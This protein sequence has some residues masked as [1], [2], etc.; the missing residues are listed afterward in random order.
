MPAELSKK[1]TEIIDEVRLLLAP[2]PDL[3]LSKLAARAGTHASALCRW[4]HRQ[5]S[6][7]PAIQR[8]VR[9]IVRAEFSRYAAHV[10]E[11]AARHGIEANG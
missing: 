2:L 9:A 6:L 10:A 5:V 4:Q 3:P 7:R 1:E 8:T 11:L